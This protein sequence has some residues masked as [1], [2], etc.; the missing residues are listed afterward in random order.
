MMSQ[1]RWT[2]SGLTELRRR[3]QVGETTGQIAE[4]LRRTPE[5]IRGMMTRLRLRSPG[6]IDA[7]G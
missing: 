6:A 2:Q 5:E 4:G 7:G 3:L 1:Q